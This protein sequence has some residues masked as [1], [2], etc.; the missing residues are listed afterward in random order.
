MKRKPT[1]VVASMLS[2]MMLVS[3]MPLAVSAANVYDE[4]IDN[5]YSVVSKQDWDL[6]P[7]IT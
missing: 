1:R 4:S 7:G 5:Y 3:T 6:S 2:A